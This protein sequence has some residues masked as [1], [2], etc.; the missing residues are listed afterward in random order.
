MSDTFKNK[1]EGS[2]F[3]LREMLQEGKITEDAYYKLIVMA[4]YEYLVLKDTQ[5][6]II[7][8]NGIPISYYEN[9]QGEQMAT[10]PEYCKQATFVADTLIS[11]GLV[12]ENMHLDP[13]LL[14]EEFAFTQKP[15]LA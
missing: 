2:V 7:L 6:A 3:A 8:L 11:T 13:P 12:D 15:G 9:M 10:D 5:N 1:L 4:A 14:Q